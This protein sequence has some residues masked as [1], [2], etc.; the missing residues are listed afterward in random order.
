MNKKIKY[1]IIT[2]MI[3]I[4]AIAV[5][6]LIKYNQSKEISAPVDENKNT[7]EEIFECNWNG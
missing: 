3:I 4:I 5:I 6:I 7:T 2:L 1:V